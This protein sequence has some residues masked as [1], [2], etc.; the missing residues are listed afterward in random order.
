[1]RRLSISSLLGEDSHDARQM[2]RTVCQMLDNG[3]FLMGASEEGQETV[4]TRATFHVTVAHGLGYISA[5]QSVTWGR[6]SAGSNFIQTNSESEVVR[7]W[8]HWPRLVIIE[9]ITPYGLLL[10]HMSPYVGTHPEY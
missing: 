4:V 8:T 2:I 9:I 1:M 3:Y 7:E 5:S 6:M 10:H